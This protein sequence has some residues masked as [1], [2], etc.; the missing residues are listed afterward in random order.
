MDRTAA[1]L[2]VFITW[3]GVATCLHLHSPQPFSAEAE[4]R[5]LPSTHH[6]RLEVLALSVVSA[7][8]PGIP[9]CMA[10][11][12]LCCNR[13]SPESPAQNPVITDARGNMLVKMPPNYRHRTHVKNPGHKVLEDTTVPKEETGGVPGIADEGTQEETS[14]DEPS[15]GEEEMAKSKEDGNSR[16]GIHD[17]KHLS[18]IDIEAGSGDEMVLPGKSIKVKENL[19]AE[20]KKIESLSDEDETHIMFQNF[21][22]VTDSKNLMLETEIPYT[23]YPKVQNNSDKHH[24]DLQ[25]NSANQDSTEINKIPQDSLVT[26]MVENLLHTNMNRKG[27]QNQIQG[28]S[29]HKEQIDD[30]ISNERMLGKHIEGETH[31][32]MKTEPNID[33]EGITV[34]PNNIKVSYLEDPVD[35]HKVGEKSDDMAMDVEVSHIAEKALEESLES[36]N[37]H[38]SSVVEGE[39]LEAFRN[40]T[41]DSEHLQGLDKLQESSGGSRAHEYKDET[42]KTV[43]DFHEASIILQDSQHENKISS[44]SPSVNKTPED[45]SGTKEDLMERHEEQ[46]IVENIEVSKTFHDSNK[47][48]HEFHDLGSIQEDSRDAKYPHPEEMAFQDPDATENIFVSSDIHKEPFTEE[49]INPEIIRTQSVTPGFE[50][51]QASDE[52]MGGFV[53]GTHRQKGDT[54]FAFTTPSFPDTLEAPEVDYR[55]SGHTPSIDM[56]EA[57]SPAPIITLVAPEL[58]FNKDDG[59]VPQSE[60]DDK[61]QKDSAVQDEDFSSSSARDNLE[62]L[63]T[64][65]TDVNTFSSD[66]QE[67]SFIL[68]GPEE[69]KAHRTTICP[70]LPCDTPGIRTVTTKTPQDLY[71]DTSDVTETAN[72]APGKEA[73]STPPPVVIPKTLPPLHLNSEEELRAF[74]LSLETLPKAGTSSAPQGDVLLDVKDLNQGKSTSYLS[75]LWG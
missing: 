6:C 13:E 58:H 39:I 9:A 18:K 36:G 24:N 54:I 68:Q 59:S 23:D 35:A 64:L 34:T 27:N 67:F 12:R 15:A 45:Y 11:F 4:C 41:K 2:C 21:L 28:S 74:L 48:S 57:T 26:G 60:N 62:S 7:Y 70:S 73:A 63:T 52:R 50:I 38:G 42:K 19:G 14:Q 22:D 32:G 10:G 29:P 71:M 25:T 53:D 17:L 49:I 61:Q 44:V 20:D 16:T 1:T 75:W 46:K 72:L 8:S 66:R 5:C 43:G 51:D 3:V 47:T 37:S 30:S 33:K 56:P 69:N 31:A 65:G 55:F 40:P